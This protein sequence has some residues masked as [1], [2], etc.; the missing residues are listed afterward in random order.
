VFVS[1]NLMR[2][3]RV[4][5]FYGRFVRRT[6]AERVGVC[7]LAPPLA[8]QHLRRHVVSRALDSDGDVVDLVQAPVA[9]L[10]QLR[11]P[12]RLMPRSALRPDPQVDDHRPRALQPAVAAAHVQHHVRGFQV[13]VHH[14]ARV[15][16]VDGA[17]DAGRDVPCM[18]D[19]ERTVVVDAVGQRAA[20]DVV[21]DERRPLLVA[22]ERPQFDDVRVVA[23]AQKERHL[24]LVFDHA[25]PVLKH[26]ERDERL[27]FAGLLCEIHVGLP[28][29]PELSHDLQAGVLWFPRKHVTLQPPPPAGCGGGGSS[30]CCV[31]ESF[32]P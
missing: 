3:E 23:D 11:N 30:S 8:A 25:D 2:F 4:G 14:A 9:R 21:G 13:A 29:G 15:H 6:D 20:V 10:L 31:C 16:V 18:R 7:F 24:P 27:G 28:A 1:L 19:G 22:V 5:R 17:G 12:V 26:F 32:S